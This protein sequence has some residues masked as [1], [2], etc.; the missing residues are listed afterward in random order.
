M[1]VAILP[2]P[3]SVANVLLL[4]LLMG[5]PDGFAAKVKTF[6]V[7]NILR[8]IQSL[9]MYENNMNSGQEKGR[10]RRTT[11]KYLEFLGATT[12]IPCSNLPR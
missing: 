5:Q 7:P 11:K 1:A 2:T 10:L 6:V 8:A 12:F 4:Q 3:D 9:A